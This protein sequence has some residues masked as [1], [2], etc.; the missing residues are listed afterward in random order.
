MLDCAPRMASLPRS[1]VASAVRTSARIALWSA[2]AATAAAAWLLDRYSKPP[3]P[4]AYVEAQ[5][6]QERWRGVDF[7]SYPEV[8]LLQEYVRIDTSYPEPNE[9]AGAEFLAKQLE[10]AGVPVTIER[11]A[12]RRANLWAFVEGEDPKAVV[13]LGHLDVEPARESQGWKYP[14]FG[15]VIEGPWIYGRGMYD[16]KSLTVAQLLAVI[17]VAQ[18]AREGRRPKRSLLFLQTSSEESGGEVGTVHVLEEHPDLVARFGTVLTEG[19]VIEAVNPS[20]VKYWGIEFAQ[21]QFAKTTVCSS[22]RAALVGVAALLRRIGK[23]QPVSELP[24]GVGE[25]LSSYAATRGAER[26]RGLLAKPE[27]LISDPARFAKL[28]PFM[29]ALFRD[30]V[31]PLEPVRQPDGSWSLDVWLHLLPGHDLEAV[32]AELLPEWAFG[33]LPHTPLELAS[34]PGISPLDHP[35]YRTLERTV[36]ERFPDAPVGPYYLPWTMTD[37]RRFRALGLPTYGFAP[38][39]VVVYDTVQIGKANERMQLPAFVAGV[40]LYREAVAR[41]VS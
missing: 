29:Q 4:E 38:F 11:F 7:T 24:E 5:A 25:F 15:G 23:G 26:F 37:A 33:G 27:A 12:D 6:D 18:A 3:T 41:M 31:A 10:A 39:P 1:P 20:E 2:L 30:E 17:D 13:L 19:G 16:M 14:P 28:T 35:D 22:D 9:V 8:R 32:S 34:P 36:A 21:K 40:A